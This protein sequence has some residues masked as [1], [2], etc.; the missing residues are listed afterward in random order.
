MIVVTRQHISFFNIQ[1]QITNTEKKLQKARE[2]LQQEEELMSRGMHIL[3]CH[4][5]GTCIVY[6]VC[7]CSVSMHHMYMCSCVL[8]T[9]VWTFMHTYVQELIM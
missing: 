9:I 7:M 4:L 6:Y 8:Y 3:L 2:H 1:R 5:C